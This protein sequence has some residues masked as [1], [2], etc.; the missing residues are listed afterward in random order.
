MSDQSDD[1]LMTQITDA[2]ENIK[3]NITKYTGAAQEFTGYVKG[4]TEQLE[5]LIKRLRECLDK[6]VEL[7]NSYASLIVKIT[8]LEA[9]IAT[10]TQ[11]TGDAATSAAT[12]ACNEKLK[13]I[14]I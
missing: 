3:R 11:I 7:K 10:L 14:L 1:P 6:L 8:T 9:Q 5:V 12:E 2:I 13:Q 4:Q